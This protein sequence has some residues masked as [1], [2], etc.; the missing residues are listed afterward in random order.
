MSNK[1]QFETRRSDWYRCFVCLNRIPRRRPTDPRQL[2]PCSDAD[3]G[4]C[5]LGLMLEP[6][7]SPYLAAGLHVKVLDDCCVFVPGAASLL[8]RQAHD[9]CFGGV[10]RRA[11]MEA[12]RRGA[13]L[14]RAS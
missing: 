12:A 5:R 2:G 10:D 9:A 7:L 6:K 4:R 14:A 8:S 11:E 1:R 13:P 3:D